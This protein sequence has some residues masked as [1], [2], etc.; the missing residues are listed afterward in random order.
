MCV[1]VTRRDALQHALTAQ[2]N[3]HRRLHDKLNGLANLGLEDLGLRTSIAG[4]EH[5]EGVGRRGGQAHGGG[6]VFYFPA[7]FTRAPAV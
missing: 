4:G 7:L 1:C 3:G 6:T 5:D 2:R